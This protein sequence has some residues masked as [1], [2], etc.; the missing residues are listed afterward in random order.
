MFGKEPVFHILQKYSS[1]SADEIL[2]AILD[3]LDKFRESAKLEDDITLVI[4]K[5]ES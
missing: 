5:I 3:A 2:E 4:I 1:S